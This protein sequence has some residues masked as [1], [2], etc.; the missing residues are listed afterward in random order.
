MKTTRTLILAALFVGITNLSFGQTKQFRLSVGQNVTLKTNADWFGSESY[1]YSDG[2]YSESLEVNEPKFFN[3]TTVGIG[4]T[5]LSKRNIGFDLGLEYHFG[6]FSTYAEESYTDTEY[7]EEYEGTY[8][9]KMN[10][11]HLNPSFVYRMDRG[12]FHPYGRIGFSAGLG[13]V[14]HKM[15]EHYT[16]GDGS[17]DEESTEDLEMDLLS[18]GGKMAIG[19]DYD[20]AP[21]M[22][23]FGEANLTVNQMSDTEWMDEWMTSTNMGVRVGIKF[24]PKG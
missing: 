18:L 11:V 9:L 5:I 22:S 19:T 23:L 24:T 12:Q 1:S 6:Q 17:Y 21:G 10:N 13:S 14:S 3:A 16:G 8:A 2:S 4:M 7:A 15:T 20:I